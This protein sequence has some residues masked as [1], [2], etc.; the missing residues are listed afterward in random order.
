MAFSVRPSIK[1]DLPHVHLHQRPPHDALFLAW[2]QLP[3]I[4][5]AAASRALKDRD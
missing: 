3:P 5:W 1:T 4:R 2:R